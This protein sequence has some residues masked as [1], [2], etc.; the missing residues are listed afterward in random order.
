MASALQ[1][2]TKLKEIIAAER[3]ERVSNLADGGPED[4]AAYREEVGYI[5]A[6][7]E[8]GS[9]CAE[10]GKQLDER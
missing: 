7:D 9:W 2:E 1:L 4:Y 10:A 6:L 5:R 3:E 8:F